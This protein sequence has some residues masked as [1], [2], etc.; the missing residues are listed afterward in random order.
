MHSPDA[1]RTTSVADDN[2]S[3][4]SP[5]SPTADSIAAALGSS[6]SSTPSSPAPG[7]YH[8]RGRS[9]S[10]NSQGSVDNDVSTYSPAAAAATRGSSSTRAASLIPVSAGSPGSPTGGAS[11]LRHFFGG[12]G[13]SIKFGDNAGNSRFRHGGARDTGGE[14][15]ADVNNAALNSSRIGAEPLMDP[16][17]VFISP[18]SF[19]PGTVRIVLLPFSFHGLWCFCLSLIHLLLPACIL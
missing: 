16:L 15:D 6:S 14:D 7:S 5:L 10:I 8:R 9:L 2:N 19:V 11:F 13:D 3:G 4:E 1:S 18:L 12:S 17:S